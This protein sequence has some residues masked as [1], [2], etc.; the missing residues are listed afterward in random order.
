MKKLIL[1]ITIIFLAGGCTWNKSN[2]HQNSVPTNTSG[3][4]SIKPMETTPSPSN[5][6]EPIAQNTPENTENLTREE[7]LERAWANQLRPVSS[8]KFGE[9]KVEVNFCGVRPYNLTYNTEATEVEPNIY[10]V[11]VVEDW[12]VVLNEERVV[13]YAFYNVTP[14]TT[15]LVYQSGGLGSLGNC[16]VPE[17]LY[18][19][20][21]DSK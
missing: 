2:E 15:E 12:N 13:R 16:S 7:A 10:G 6:P 14:N 19:T 1:S 17:N 11:T 20:M 3:I 21:N 9:T 18:G 4:E 5:S 8:I